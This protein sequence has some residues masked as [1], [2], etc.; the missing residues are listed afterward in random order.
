VINP[1]TGSLL[2]TEA[3]GHA[4]RTAG[5]PQQAAARVAERCHGPSYYGRSYRGQVTGYEVLV[6]EGWTNASPAL[7]PPSAWLGPNGQKG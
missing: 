3:V 7:P 1:Q 6:S 4:P 2:A 5:C